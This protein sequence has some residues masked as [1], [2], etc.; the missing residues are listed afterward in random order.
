MFDIEG[1]LK[2]GKEIVDWLKTSTTDA[3]KKGW[4]K[5][6]DTYEEWKEK[7]PKTE[8]SV[9][10]KF[11]EYLKKEQAAGRIP[12]KLS[13]GK[14]SEIFRD[15]L[16]KTLKREKMERDSRYPHIYRCCF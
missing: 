3:L 4:W 6:K 9:L 5:M 15:W 10:T 13:A 11:D 16:E 12:K 2:K 8:R 14:L 1:W 7:L